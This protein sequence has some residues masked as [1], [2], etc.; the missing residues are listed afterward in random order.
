MNWLEKIERNPTNGDDVPISST[1]S[2][3]LATTS[4]VT[5]AFNAEY[6]FATQTPTGK[7][8]TRPYNI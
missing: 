8:I 1:Y 6:I 5:I 2:F 4:L 7:Q 3:V